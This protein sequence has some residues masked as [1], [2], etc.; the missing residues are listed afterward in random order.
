MN[1]DKFFMKIAWDVASRSKEPSTKVGCVIVDE[2]N[3]IIATGCNDYVMERG[4]K[5]S[6]DKK[7]VRYLISIHAEMR[8]LITAKRSVKNCKVY[9]THASCENCLKH[10]ILAGV[11]EIIYDKLTTNT[12][13]IQ[14]DAMEA[15][16]RM[17]KSTDIINRNING[18]S[19]IEDLKLN[20]LFPKKLLRTPLDK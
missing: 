14:E 4:S 2:D 7:P 10:L 9:V 19:Y 20:N 6:T 12:G 5:Y 18:I 8:A 13:F 1:L 17:M 16:I 11:K 3:N 15:I